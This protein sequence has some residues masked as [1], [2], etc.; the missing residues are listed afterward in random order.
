MWIEVTIMEPDENGNPKTDGVQSSGLFND[1]HL[2]GIEPLDRG[3]GTKGCK[4]FTTT[5]V[6][7]T[8]IESYEFIRSLLR[9]EF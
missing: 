5:G 1:Q 7:F 4:L 3:D 2:W 9:K 8:V 6:G